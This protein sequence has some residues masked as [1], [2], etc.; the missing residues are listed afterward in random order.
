SRT[1]TYGPILSQTVVLNKFPFFLRR[2][3]MQ[4]QTGIFHLPKGFH[5]SGV[6]CGLKKSKVDLA[7]LY[8]EVPAQAAGVYTTN[9]IKAAPL[10]LSKT[11]LTDNSLQAIIVNSANANACT[12]EQGF[13]NA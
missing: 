10:T 3:F 6:H 12:G 9:Q 11:T 13:K 2:L 7:Y 4:K 5:A 1:L 8:S